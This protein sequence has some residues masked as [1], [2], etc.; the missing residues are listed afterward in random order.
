MAITNQIDFEKYSSDFKSILSPGFVEMMFEC[1]IVALDSK[2][3]KSKCRLL[4]HDHHQNLYKSEY[5]LIWKREVDEIMKRSH[6]DES[7]TTDFGAMFLSLTLFYGVDEIKKQINEDFI[8]E[9]TAK[10]TGIDFWICRNSDL[11]EFIAR[12]EVSGIRG[13][14]PSN[15]M[16]G[17]L[18]KKQEQSKQSDG[19]NL[20]VFISIIEFSGPKSLIQNKEL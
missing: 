4:S 5:Q 12:I 6:N 13:E 16:N 14:T 19:T 3:Q 17:R 9:T 1:C 20:P 7:R 2:N 8:V 18:K 11:L 15:T 10:G